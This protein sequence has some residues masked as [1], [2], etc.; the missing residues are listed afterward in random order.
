MFS[1]SS[2]LLYQA[3]FSFC[4]SPQTFHLNLKAPAHNLLFCVYIQADSS[5]NLSVKRGYR[6]KGKALQP[7]HKLPYPNATKYLQYLQSQKNAFI[8]PDMF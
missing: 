1:W 8:N 4:N 6:L 5:G 7:H 3:S 2:L